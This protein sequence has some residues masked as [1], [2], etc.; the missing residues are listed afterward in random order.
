MLHHQAKCMTVSVNM[1]NPK[2]FLKEHYENKESDTN[3]KDDYDKVLPLS[4]PLRDDHNN[5]DD[6]NPT[7]A[8]PE[9]FSGQIVEPSFN[10]E[11]VAPVEELVFMEPIIRANLP[12]YH[13]V[14]TVPN[15]D[16]N[17]IDKITF[18]RTINVIFEDTIHWKKNLFLVPSG[19]PGNDFLEL[20]TDWLQKFNT[21]SSFQCLAMKVLNI[22]PN[23]LLQKPSATSK[24]KDHYKALKENLQM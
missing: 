10:I 15:S 20:Y 17:N 12:A 13:K 11:N 18:A 19:K 6:V 24:A 8:I 21:N 23:M 14:A 2:S 3:K 9:I 5:N 1:A 22:L 4:Q 16:Y 7:P